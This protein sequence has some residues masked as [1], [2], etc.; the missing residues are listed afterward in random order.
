MDPE[1][2]QTTCRIGVQT[3]NGECWQAGLSTSVFLNGFAAVHLAV[4]STSYLGQFNIN[5]NFDNGSDAKYLSEIF[6]VDHDSSQAPLTWSGNASSQVSL[7]PDQ[8]ITAVSTPSSKSSP[9]SQPNPVPSSTTRASGLGKGAIAGLSVGSTLVSGVLILAAVLFVLRSR[10]RRRSQAR[11]SGML[12]PVQ[13]QAEMTAP[14]SSGAPTELAG[15]EDQW[16]ELSDQTAVRELSATGGNL[17]QG[18]LSAHRIR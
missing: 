17:V 2:V 4:A 14:S 7:S 3:L 5:F 11:R 9:S 12:K 16:R 1:C 15:Q 10:R 6:H 13:F 18:E 8:S